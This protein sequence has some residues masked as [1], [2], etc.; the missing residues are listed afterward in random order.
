[1]AKPPA[2][3]P[4]SDIKGVNRDEAKVVAGGKEPSSHQQEQLA[5][6][7]DGDAARPPHDPQITPQ[8]NAR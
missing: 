2:S 3:P 1:M 8:G 6:V 5:A 4:S 7:A